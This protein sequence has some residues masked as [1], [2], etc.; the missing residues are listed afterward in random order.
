LFSKRHSKQITH[1][2]LWTK[3]GASATDMTKIES[4]AHHFGLSIVSTDK[5]RRIIK[6]HGSASQM[7]KAFH[8]TLDKYQSNHQTFIGRSGP[9]SVPLFLKN[10]VQ[11][12]FGLDTRPI[13]TPKL[14]IKDSNKKMAISEAYTPTQLSTIYNFPQATGRGQTIALIELGGGYTLSDIQEYF[15][16]LQLQPPKIISV[17]VDGGFNNPT[18]PDSADAEVML[19]IEVAGAVA[20]NADIVVYFAPNTDS[21]FLNAISAAVHDTKYNPSIISISWG[22]PE[23]N[24]TSQALDSFNTLFQEA[25]SV[26]ITV[27]AAAGDRGSSDGILDGLAHVDFPSSSPYV[28]A[29][30][31]TSLVVNGQTIQSETVWHDSIDS[32]T[33][34]GISDIFNVPVY[35]QKIKLPRSVNSN[36]LGRG[37]PDLAAVADPQTGYKVLVDGQSFVIGG[38][39]AVAPLMSGL[40]ARINERKKTKVGFIHPTL[41]ASASV[42]RD[43]TDGDNITSNKGYKA[44]KGWDACTGN[45]VPDGMKL[46]GLF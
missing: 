19:D 34:G 5:N 40:L 31:G 27:C 6:L 36:K 23:S 20:S 10:S 39:S 44:E 30:G 14:R 25:A 46:L 3:H 18:T 15:Q 35:Q 37:V 32:A 8:V 42:C 38:T 33:G 24:W 21:G 12:V 1:Q 9:I 45:G 29:C 26:G 4:F 28:L 7:Q 41:Y 43:I 2:Q 17:S 13:A 16:G 11:G 22:G